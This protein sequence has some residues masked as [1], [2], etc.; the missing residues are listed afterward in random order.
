[1]HLPIVKHLRAIGR[2]LPPWVGNSLIGAAYVVL[3]LLFLQKLAS[4]EITHDP[5]PEGFVSYARHI[6]ETGTLMEHRRPPGYPFL[7]AWADKIGPGSMHE[8]ALNLHRTVLFI[9]F[10]VFIGWIRK[11]F[12]N[13]VA[14]LTGSMF[15]IGDNYF[16]W[17]GSLM[18]A[19]LF[20]SLCFL[21][22]VWCSLNLFQVSCRHKIGFFSAYILLVF[23]GQSFHSSFWVRA[24][25]F[26]VVSGGFLFWQN[27]NA[28][29]AFLGNLGLN[30]SIL[31][32]VGWG[33]AFLSNTWLSVP[34]E[35]SNYVN[36]SNKDK[37]QK[38]FV[39]YWFTISQLASL[40]PPKNPVS[41]D[42]KIEEAKRSCS[43]E[44]G[45]DIEIKKIPSISGPFTAYGRVFEKNKV[46]LSFWQ[47]R[48]LDHPQYLLIPFFREM[49]LQYH[50]ILRDIMPYGS[51]STKTF[52]VIQLAPPTGSR[53]SDLFWQTGLDLRGYE[54]LPFWKKSFGIFS[55]VGKILLLII[56]VFVGLYQ[57]EIR[58]N[59]AIVPVLL[60]GAIWL[61]VAANISAAETRYLLPYLPAFFL[62]ISL[63]INKLIRISKLI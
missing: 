21:G 47:K 12:G 2:R 35:H 28:Q 3:F 15:A 27:R 63:S 41:L 33:S 53:L 7:L 18:M 17:I 26:L 4:L 13:L 45:Y 52:N 16:V 19:D 25:I 56:F 29:N 5:D 49:K 1:M 43:K 38:N 40:P 48:I 31:F 10:I 57:K 55:E 6:Q 34:T 11:T 42:K 59:L 60:S 20:L 23:L 51:Q 58:K 61:F 32:L 22:F 30:L 46:P 62:L 24:L 44:L 54:S 50:R 39:T 14:L 37:S 9:F 8:D 36:L